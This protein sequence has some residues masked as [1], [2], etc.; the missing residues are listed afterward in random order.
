M[1]YFSFFHQKFYL[2]TLIL[3]IIFTLFNL[4]VFEEIFNVKIKLNKIVM[5]FNQ[6]QTRNKHV[7]ISE[8]KLNFNREKSSETSDHCPNNPARSQLYRRKSDF[9]R[10]LSPRTHEKL[11]AANLLLVMNF[12]WKSNIK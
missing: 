8:T 7:D 2:S 12:N 6:K 5:K 10:S 3:N 1:N 9:A 4:N 11:S